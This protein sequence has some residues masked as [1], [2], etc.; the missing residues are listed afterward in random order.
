MAHRLITETEALA[1]LKPV[2]VNHL[3]FFE[4]I[5][6]T[7]AEAGRWIAAG[8]PD[9][10]LVLA[11]EQ[12]QGRGRQGRQW[13]TPRGAALALSLILKPEKMAL[14]PQVGPHFTALGALAVCEALQTLY[15]LD[16]QIKWPNDVLLG[17]EKVAGV[18]VEAIWQGSDLV[19]LIL[20][21]GVNVF[22]EAA[23]PPSAVVLPATSVQAHAAGHPVDRLELLKAIVARSIDWL[24]RVADSALVAAWAARLAYRYQWV[25]VADPKSESP[26]RAY[27]RGLAQ[28]GALEVVTAAGAERRL[29][30]GEISLRPWPENLVDQNPNL[31]AHDA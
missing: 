15:G 8:A 22:A 3:R 2:G 9:R 25:M 26:Y 5:D 13:I 29:T 31:E 20:G 18:L 6:S 24:A 10:A 7:N 30:G 4:V 12:T 11:E 19:A 28:D 27:I 21:I 17:G 1:A 23:P 16:A 14:P